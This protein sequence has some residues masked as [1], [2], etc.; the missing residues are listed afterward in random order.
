M[1]RHLQALAAIV[2]LL[3][4][5]GGA[6]ATRAQ[7]ESADPAFSGHYR[8]AE[9]PSEARARIMRAAEP[10]LRTLNP[11]VRAVAE[12][13][14]RETMVPSRI[15]LSVRGERVSV[16]YVGRERERT[17]RSRLNHPRTITNDDGHSARLTHLFRAG[18]L[19]QIFEGERGGR[20][21][22]VFGLDERRRQLTLS[23]VITQERLAQPVR[24]ELP[25]VRSD[26]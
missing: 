24:I 3:V 1:S 23:V 4:L 22:N 6:T 20:W 25:Y 21:Y 10:V 14:L 13:Q 15:D 26:G 17:F 18:Q 8:Y 12:Q 7:V 2:T 16:R 19:E 11:V 5:G 9:S